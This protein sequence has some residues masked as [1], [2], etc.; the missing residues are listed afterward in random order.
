MKQKLRTLTDRNHSQSMEE[1]IR[2]LNAY[3]RGW[4]GY[5]A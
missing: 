1:R 4:I 2:R 3:L 5:Y